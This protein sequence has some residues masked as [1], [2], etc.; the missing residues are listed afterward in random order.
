VDGCGNRKGM[1][2]LNS[3]YLRLKTTRPI[4]PAYP[5]ELKTLGDHL[6][7]VR[8]DRELSQVDVARLIQVTVDTVTGWELNRFNPTAKLA[9]R[10]IQFLDYF[11]FA[12]NAQ[13]LGKQLYHARQV[14]GQT[15][16]Q[17]AKVI[18]CDASNLRCIELDQRKPQAA[19]CT[20]IQDYINATS[21]DC[22]S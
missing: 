9:R 15:Q 4:N 16:K 5:A 10:I 13:S 2:A 20:K 7:K 21:D 3:C 12:H 19:T 8:L 17:V 22:G 1:V 14:N 6:R 11:P 18:G